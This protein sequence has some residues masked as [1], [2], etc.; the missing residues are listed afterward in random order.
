MLDLGFLPRSRVRLV[1]Q[2]EFAEC[3]LASLAMVANYHG[4]DIDLGTLRRRFAPS[5]RGAPLRSLIGLADKIGLT[6]RP[7]K[8]PLEELRNLHTPAFCIGI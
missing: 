1:R 3:G 7:V 4:L 8:L 5:L 2:T 6:P